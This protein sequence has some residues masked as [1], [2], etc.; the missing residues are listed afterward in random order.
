MYTLKVAGQ[1]IEDRQALQPANALK[2][3]SWNIPLPPTASLWY[4]LCHLWLQEA[5]T[6][7][8]HCQTMV[9]FAWPTISRQAAVGQAMSSHESWTWSGDKWI[10]NDP[11]V[12][13]EMIGMGMNGSDS[14]WISKLKSLY[15]RSIVTLK[16][17]ENIVP[18]SV[19]NVIGQCLGGTLEDMYSFYVWE[20]FMVGWSV[21]GVVFMF[22][23]CFFHVFSYVLVAGCLKNMELKILRTCQF[24]NIWFYKCIV[25]DI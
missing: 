7:A 5:P 15:H 17:S 11:D 8:W 6:W 1:Y 19:G 13:L 9:D 24:A 20:H 10:W 21:L 14:S 23:P 22:F 4:E 18:T 16:T 3:D 2:P 25:F 12:G